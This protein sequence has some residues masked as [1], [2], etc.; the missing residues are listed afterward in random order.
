MLLAL[1]LA[2]PLLA[3]PACPPSPESL[4]ACRGEFGQAGLPLPWSDD[5][6]AQLL[7]PSGADPRASR[8]GAQLSLSCPGQ[9]PVV[10]WTAPVPCA[11]SC[12]PGGFAWLP[13]KA[14]TAWQQSRATREVGDVAG[15]LSHAEAAARAYPEAE[16]VQYWLGFLSAESGDYPG[17]LRA[18]EHA[19]RLHPGDP[20]TLYQRALTERIAG[21]SDASAAHVE[22]AL[23][24]TPPGHP[25]LSRVQ[26]LTAVTRQE[27]GAEGFA[28]LGRAA[29]QGGFSACCPPDGAK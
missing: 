14:W 3:G 11:P 1:S 16:R 27:R 20:D 12:L 6:L 25:G 4:P 26:C 28:E 19:L 22:E 9:A 10:W 7:C 17:A 18:F 5:H 24:A 23:A 13:E 21:M 8:E 2:A 29:C 15:A